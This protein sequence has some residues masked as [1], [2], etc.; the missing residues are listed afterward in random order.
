[1][2]SA[3]YNRNDDSM[4]CGSFHDELT[5]ADGKWINHPILQRDPSTWSDE[6]EYFFIDSLFDDFVVNPIT[7]SE[8]DAVFRILEGGHRVHTI[9]KFMGNEMKYNGLYFKEMSTTI[10]DIFKYRKIRYTIYQGLSDIE[11]EQFI[12]RVNM[13]LPINSGEFVNMM[14]SIELCELARVLAE[15]HAP[16][17]IEFTDMAG[18]KNLRGDASMAMYMLLSNFIKND[19][20][21]TERISSV[22]KLREDAEKHRGVPLDTEK[23]SNQIDK[24][25][26]IFDRLI[27]TNREDNYT[28]KPQIKWPRYI[29]M[30]IQA[31]LMKFPDVEASAIREFISIVH[32]HTSKFCPV[33]NYWKASVPD[34]HLAAKKFCEQR[35]TV[36]ERWYVE[37]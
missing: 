6:Q 30:T 25:M 12:L 33:K 29:I 18:T 9:K 14:P 4:M 11:E 24:L 37:R 28:K 1:M 15:R 23:L 2:T 22:L 32:G 16:T 20:V 27:P 3:K 17:L 5:R 7:V 26:S 34:A 10:R 36:F 31:I 21:Q 13:G 19:L 8:R 35:C